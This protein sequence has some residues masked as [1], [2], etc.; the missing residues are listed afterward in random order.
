MKKIIVMALMLAVIAWGICAQESGVI[1]E[2]TG[3]V[4]L[5]HAGSA[6]FT[7]ASTGS[8]V[9]QNTVVSTG[10]KSTALI[11]VG[12]STIMVHPLTRLSL[13][14]IQASSGTETM[15]MKLQS[16]R[17]KVDVKPPAGTKAS[18][19]VQSPS[20]TAS[21]RGTSFEF[22]TRSL[23]VSEGTVTFI[24]SSGVQIPVNAGGESIVG[25]EGK[26]SDP[27]GN[28]NEN[29]VPP[30]PTGTDPGSKAPTSGQTNIKGDF[31][32]ELQYPKE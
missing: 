15:N 17:V 18:F 4:Q 32:I 6:E 22:D 12:C 25:G 1:Q 30:P 21:V 14:E 23:K 20:A 9:K 7:A 8:E 13:A 3:D 28:S 19:T 29:I 26:A 11:A 10:F 31:T 2:F 5:K 27:A 24:G 16:G